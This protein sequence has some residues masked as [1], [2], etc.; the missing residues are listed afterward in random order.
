MCFFAEKFV[1]LPPLISGELLC[2][3]CNIYIEI[4]QSTAI[5]PQ[6]QHRIVIEPKHYLQVRNLERAKMYMENKVENEWRMN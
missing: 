5:I 3:S 1:Y 4:D 2:F 6:I